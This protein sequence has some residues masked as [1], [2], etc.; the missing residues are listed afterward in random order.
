M[1]QKKLI[2]VALAAAS[3][4]PVPALADNANVNIYGLANLSFDLTNNGN[5]G[6]QGVSTNKVSSNASRIGFKGA[7]DM[8]DGLSAI[9]QVESRVDMDN[10]GGI[11]GSRNTFAGLKG[12]SWGQM[13]W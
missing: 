4:L 9:W 10:A 6:T 11:L 5:N 3:A 13:I 7:E 1:M 8:G 12:E 2:V